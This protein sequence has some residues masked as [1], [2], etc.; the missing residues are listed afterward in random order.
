MTRPTDVRTTMQAEGIKLGH[1]EQLGRIVL[2]TKEFGIGDVVLSEKPLIVYP[3][4]LLDDAR[5]G[6]QYLNAFSSASDEVQAKILDMCHPPLDSTA[7]RVKAWRAHAERLA[8]GRQE[9]VQI[10]HKLL[11]ISATNAHSYT[12][13]SVT[14]GEHLFSGDKADL[15]SDRCALFAMASKV[16]HSCLPNVTYDSKNA[17]GS[18]EYRAIRSIGEGD[19]ITYVYCDNLWTDSTVAR[20]KLLHEGKNFTCMCVRCAAPDDTRSMACPR[21]C[22]SVARPSGITQGEWSC[23]KCGALT[24]V[25][26]IF[27]L[28]QEQEI[29]QSLLNIKR[30]SAVRGPPPPE[31]LIDLIDEAEQT[32]SPTHH[33]AILGFETLSTVCVSHAAATQ[34]AR[35]F[36]MQGG[37]FGSETSLRLHSAMASFSQVKIMECVAAGCTKGAKYSESHPPVHE[38][39]QTAFYAA[40]DLIYSPRQSRPLQLLDFVSKYVPHMHAMYGASDA[41]VAKLRAVLLERGNSSASASKPDEP[42]GEPVSVSDPVDDA[43][44]WLTGALILSERSSRRAAKGSRKKGKGKR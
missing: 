24:H 41:D 14:F 15:Q 7:E 22:G 29:T 18:M 13:H 44:D 17:G 39:A 8:R 5:S 3:V 1:D 35:S 2:A 43:S 31:V 36:G 20:R 11:L 34:Q 37:P 9:Y 25:D 28:H 33:V 27:S 4:L 16:A 6:T 42:A 21:M 26:M 23:S 38:G 32:L 30:V 12:G 40:Q 19:M 10:I